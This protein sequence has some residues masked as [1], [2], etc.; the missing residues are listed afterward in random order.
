[1]F[2]FWLLQQL[3]LLVPLLVM[4]ADSTNS[5][6]NWPGKSPLLLLLLLWRRCRCLQHRWHDRCTDCKTAAAQFTTSGRSCQPYSPCTIQGRR[7]CERGR[8]SLEQGS[9]HDVSLGSN[10]TVSTPIP[11]RPC[12]AGNDSTLL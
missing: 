10:A 8:K 12:Y 2:Q 6:C 7:Q 1:V 3:L 11:T 5:S 9:L 4:S